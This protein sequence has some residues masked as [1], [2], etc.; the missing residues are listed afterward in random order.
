MYQILETAGQFQVVYTI[1]GG[2]TVVRVLNEYGSR[3]E[4]NALLNDLVA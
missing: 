3:A 1:N 2:K 4:A